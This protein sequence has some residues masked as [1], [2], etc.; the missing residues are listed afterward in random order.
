MK[1]SL[2]PYT[3]FR[4]YEF[5]TKFNI[6]P[7]FQN[8]TKSDIYVTFFKD[9]KTP[10]REKVIEILKEC[11]RKKEG[12]IELVGGVDEMLECF[13]KIRRIEQNGMSDLSSFPKYTDFSGKIVCVSNSDVI[14]HIKWTLGKKLGEFLD[15]PFNFHKIERYV[16]DYLWCITGLDDGTNK[17]HKMITDDWWRILYAKLS[18]LCNIGHLDL[19]N[20][21]KKDR[22]K[23]PKESD[24][25]LFD[26]FAYN[27]QIKYC[28][29]N[30]V[31][32]LRINNSSKITTA[33]AAIE[34]FHN[35][36]KPLRKEMMFFREPTKKASP[37]FKPIIRR[38]KGANYKFYLAKEIKD[39]FPNENIIIENKEDIKN[40]Q[41]FIVDSS[42][43][44]GI[45]T[46]YGVENVIIVEIPIETNSRNNIYPIYC[47][48]G[49]HCRP[50]WEAIEEFLYE[51]IVIHKYFMNA[52]NF[53]NVYKLIESEVLER[54][55]EN[56][57]MYLMGNLA[58]P[59]DFIDKLDSAA[60]KFPFKEAYSK[61]EVMQII[62][63]L[64]EN[65]H[66]DENEI[67]GIID[68]V[69]EVIPIGFLSYKQ[70]NDLYY[71]VIL[72]NL[73]KF[74][75]KIA[76]LKENQGKYKKN[77]ESNLIYKAVEE[78]YGS[79]NSYNYSNRQS[80]AS[81]TK[82]LEDLQNEIVELKKRETSHLQ[83]IRK[84]RENQEEY[85]KQQQ[86]LIRAVFNLQKRLDKSQNDLIDSISSNLNNLSFTFPNSREIQKAKRDLEKFE[87]NFNVFE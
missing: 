80:S 84:L 61:H 82:Q 53:S 7:L 51:V 54:F 19:I 63:E 26:K 58:I 70:L 8:D 42:T 10:N 73:L 11:C 87:E 5:E 27:V 33:Y 68:K 25:K 72:R 28:I 81:G 67:N 52:N 9:T 24:F 46:K 44:D 6:E 3:L 76:R 86:K 74:F 15:S 40:K 56:S 69:F 43:F 20:L 21:Q 29:H 55:F 59:L 47:S 71:Q 49:F 38:F 45:L 57:E 83:E 77:L 39:A 50:V 37:N 17:Y 36:V 65:H 34:Y 12:P 35:A 66:V 64:V 31:H 30:L 13:E 18:S 41:V 85:E 4:L 22:F 1:I 2:D 60:F 48:Y 23:D 32:F 16:A 75:P 78:F 62:D 14:K 79:K